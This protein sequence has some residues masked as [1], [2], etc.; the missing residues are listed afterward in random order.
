MLK[1]NTG[2]VIWM[3]GLSGSGKTTLSSL[4]RLKLN[5]LGINSEILDGDFLRLGLNSD[6]GFTIIDR[7][8][9]V[10]RVAEVSKILSNVVDVVFVAL[11]TPTDEMRNLARNIVGHENFKL[12]FID[13]SFEQ[14]ELRDVKGLYKSARKNQIANFTGITS[15]FQNPSRYDLRI[16]TEKFST[17]ECVQYFLENIEF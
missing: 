9:N 1:R 16:N 10:R 5:D 6:L 2:K 15:E 13:S 8:E 3:T 17:S 12:V 14:C 7:L 11:I 4:L